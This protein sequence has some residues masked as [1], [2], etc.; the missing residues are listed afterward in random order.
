MTTL[1]QDLR[2][3]LRMLAKAPGFT[4]VAIVT[5]ALGIG[6]NTALF[7]VVRAVLLRPL[8]Y[9][10]AGDLVLAQTVQKEPRQRW[11]T[12]P[13]DFYA[14]RQRN[15]TLE[16]LASF[17]V[18]PVN[19]TGGGEP[20]R[21][22]ALI[23]SSNFFAVLGREP[24][25]GRSLGMADEQWGAHRVAI[26]TD[27]L[28]RRRFDGNPAIVGQTIRLDSSSYTVVGVLP[29]RFAF[30]PASTQLF[31]PMA[32]APG[33][34]LNTHNNYFLTMVGRLKGGIS[35]EQAL[36][37]VNAIMGQIERE[38]PENKGL[39][40]D[41]TPL[42]EAIVQDIRPAILILMGAVGFVLLIACA[43]LANL[44]LA[45]AA[46]RRR[47]IAIRAALGAGRGRLL[48][49][50]FTEGVLL[51][52]LGGAAGLLLA[53]WSMG[54]VHLLG[55]TLLPRSDEIHVD[56]WVLGFALAVTVVTGIAAELAPALHSSRVNSRDALNQ[57]LGS[58]GTVGGRRG[59]RGLVVAEIALS[60]VLLI[61]AGLMLKSVSRLLRVDT[62]FDPRG[63]LTAEIDLPRQEY[64]D[65]RLARLFLPEA[66]ARSSQFFDAV[67]GGVRALPG[68]Q[69]VGLTSGL[70]L[71]GENW[72]KVI[73][74]YDRPL[75]S[76]IRDLPPIQYRVVAGDYFRAAG[77]RML[78]G[79]AFTEHDTLRSLPVAIVNQELVRRYWNG[80][81][82]IGKLMSV[83]PP[84]ELVPAGTLPPN[85]E[86]PQKFRVVGVAGDAR[87][88]GLD[89]APLPL[90][91][92][93]YAQGAEGAVNMFLLVRTNREPLT[94]VPAVRTQIGKIDADQPVTN[95]ATLESRVT[96]S[97]SLS[98]LLTLVLGAFAGLAAL[99]AAV[100]IYGVMWSSVRQRTTEIGIRMALGAEPRSVVVEVLSAGLR[101]ILAGIGIGLVAALALSRALSGLL[102]QVR[103]IDPPTYAA[104][105]SLL[106]A[107]ALFACYL[108]A[109]RAARVDPMTALR[110]E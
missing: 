56:L 12:A 49:Q 13:P 9:R 7:S 38:H 82:P 76:H 24:L 109:R 67:V 17:Y 10:S 52:G 18:R 91:Y 14:I 35:R 79:R 40:T 71:G 104:V 62:G 27:G 70:P 44:L 77:V 5:L 1:L 95:F 37:D 83:N 46:G 57:R 55:P 103:P 86:G 25:M 6:A 97:A 21:V 39:A 65:E 16:S 3:G 47:E 78:R 41:L 99:M 2:Y 101:L 96:S 80:Q 88:G 85:Y 68:V 106:A 59:T 108:P 98:R 92:V 72:G 31:L 94:L 26:L 105:A 73:T 4:A 107:A 90:V 69:A 54:A 50:L 110:A 58:T 8:P 74:F 32:F 23:V 89:R 19:L 36:A 81:D 75:P 66:Y 48:R 15:R 42:Q 100:G 45:R 33:D 34:N 30:D 93:P 20:E 84:P 63:V 11:A 51:A 87:Y 43:N 28:W 22:R 61:G 29:P 60:L 102:F 64:V 53:Y